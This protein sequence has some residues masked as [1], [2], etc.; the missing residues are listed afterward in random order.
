MLLDSSV[1]LEHFAFLG[2]EDLLAIFVPDWDN[3]SVEKKSIAATVKMSA[4]DWELL[5][6]AAAH[7]WPGAPVTRSSTI[8]A[9]AKIGAQS[10][11]PKHPT[12]RGEKRDRS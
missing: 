3:A 6:R 7:I 10:V 5:E 8:L 11:L 9:L 12:R 2:H 1:H 4:T